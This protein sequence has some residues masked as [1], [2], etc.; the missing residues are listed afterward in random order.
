MTSKI[1]MTSITRSNTRRLRINQMLTLLSP[2]TGRTTRR[3]TRMLITQVKRRKAKINRRT[4]GITRGTLIDRDHRL[5]T[6]ASLIIIRPPNAT[7]LSLTYN[8]DLLRTTRRNVSRNIISKI[9]TMRSNLKRT[10]NLLSKVRRVNR[11]IKQHM[12]KSTVM[13]N[14]KARLNRRDTIIIALTTGIRLRNPTGTRMLTNSRLRRNNLMLR[15]LIL[16]GQLN[17]G[18]LYGSNLSLINNDQG[19][20]GMI[21]YIIKDTT[22]RLINSVMTFKSN[23][24]RTLRITSLGTNGLKRVLTM[25]NGLLTALSARNNVKTRNKGSLGIGAIIY[26]GLLI[27][28]GTINKI[29]NDTSRTSIKLLSRIATNGT[30]LD[31]LSINGIPSLLD[32]L[33]I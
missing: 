4:S 32:N 30:N 20:R 9:R 28:F 16:N 18:T 29:I 1:I 26:N 10:T 2:L 7:I 11:L 17:N 19:M 31:R 22:T 8:Q 24:L 14:I 21:R 6:R 3:T 5:L 12:I 23:N 15:S 25:I 33:T 13:T 27:P